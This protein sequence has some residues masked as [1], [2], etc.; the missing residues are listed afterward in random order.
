MNPSFAEVGAASRNAMLSAKVYKTIRRVRR[1]DPLEEREQG[2][3][4]R[5]TDLLSEVVQGSLLIDRK[6]LEEKGFY[7]N[8][9]AYRHALSALVQLQRDENGEGQFSKDVTRVFKTYRADLASL[10]RGR[11]VSERRL[12][13]LA[14]FFRILSELFFRDVQAPPPIHREPY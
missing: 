7:A 6:P 10:S 5:G 14:E 11:K 8:L 1:G 3:L 2:I 9:K 4:S 13:G 12:D